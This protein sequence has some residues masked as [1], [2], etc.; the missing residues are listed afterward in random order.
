MRF[1]DSLTTI[2]AGPL[3]APVGA[4]AAWRQLVDLAGRGRLAADTST[5]DRLRTL[6]GEVPV[7]VRAASARALAFAQPPAALVTFFAEDEPAVAAPVLRTAALDDAD[8]LVLLP[9]LDARGRSVL[10]HRRDLPDMVRR[11]LDSFGASDFVLEHAQPPV[12]LPAAANDA[13]PDIAS[14][15][16]AVAP[17]VAADLPPTAPVPAT[18]EPAS[19]FEI[20]DLLARID[21]FSR[22]RTP[23]PVTSASDHFFFETDVAGTVRWVDGVPRGVLVGVELARLPTGG[24]ATAIRRRHPFTGTEL[25]IA[26]DG[27]A[28]GRWRLSGLPLFDATGGRFTGMRGVGRRPASPSRIPAQAAAADADSLRQLV[29]ELRTPANAIMGFAELIEAELLGPVPVHYR[30]QAG[31]IRDEAGA[32]V[33]AVEDLD[34]AARIEGGA[35]DLR[36]DR[37]AVAPLLE[38]VTEAVRPIAFLRGVAVVTRLDDDLPAVSGDERAVERLAARLIAVAV[39]TGEPG[40]RLMVA[41]FAGE[42]T[43]HLAIDRPRGLSADADAALFKLDDDANT[44]G[45]P[46]VPLLGIGFTLRLVGNLARQ[47]GGQLAIGPERLT[48]RL[49]AGCDRNV[50]TAA[51]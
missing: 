50:R 30:A 22:D 10:R 48:L 21:G 12:T 7:E 26:G 32:L 1:D 23:A 13:D 39:A 41:A 20:A 35:L 6:R 3:Q 16:P 36:P 34:T 51:S 19:R 29:H 33:A 11:G 4:R 2:L 38:R 15:E 5:L 43:L 9:R 37:V 8:W 49:P 28:A 18:G 40:E 44:D 47:L 45:R 42:G 24:V 46:G 14:T 25:T 31:T 27:A 17:P